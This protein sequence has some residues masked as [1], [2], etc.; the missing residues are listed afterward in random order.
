MIMSRSYDK[1]V[2]INTRHKGF[3]KLTLK[4]AATAE[5]PT[6][7]C[8]C[9]SFGETQILDN[10]QL[11]RLSRFSMDKLRA[12]VFFFP[13][14]SKGMPGMPRPVK[15][16]KV[17]GMP[18]LVPKVDVSVLEDDYNLDDLTDLLHRRYYT[19]LH[20]VFEENK[21]GSLHPEDTLSMNPPVEFINDAEFEAG[22]NSIL[23]ISATILK[24]PSD[25][26]AKVAPPKQ[27]GRNPP[28]LGIEAYFTGGF[29]FFFP[30]LCGHFATFADATETMTDITGDRAELIMW[31]YG[32]VGFFVKTMF[33]D[34]AYFFVV[35]VV[36]SAWVEKGQAAKSHQD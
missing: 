3:L 6:S 4:L 1:E 29:F 27:E 2:Q 20:R 31:S 26:E 23:N 33:L 25:A 28:I 34:T 16:T 35:S 5:Q 15:L 19:E 9:Y 22:W 14:G 13:Y 11:P 30:M 18:I 7:V 10:V 17:V 12:N 24:Q 21:A 36:I 32:P 8:P